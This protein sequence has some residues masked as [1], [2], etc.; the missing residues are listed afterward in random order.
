MSYFKTDCHHAIKFLMLY[1]DSSLCKRCC[2]MDSMFACW[3]GTLVTAVEVTQ[4]SFFSQTLSGTLVGVVSD[5]LLV[6]DN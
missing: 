4:K 2:V 1:H 3:Q 5:I 6:A